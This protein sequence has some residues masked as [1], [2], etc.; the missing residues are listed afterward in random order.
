MRRPRRATPGRWTGAWPRWL[1]AACHCG[2]RLTRPRRRP[3]SRPGARA[4][5]VW[6]AGTAKRSPCSRSASPISPPPSPDSPCRRHPRKPV[7]AV[8]RFAS[9]SAAARWRRCHGAGRC[10]L[11]PSRP[12]WTCWPSRSHASPR[13]TAGCRNATRKP[14]WRCCRLPL[15]ARATSISSTSSR[16][17]SRTPGRARPSA[18][19]ARRRRPPPRSARSLRSRHC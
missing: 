17:R 7:R 19:G 2:W 6:S 18:R 16:Q 12:M 5:R 14:S 11:T 1:L 15:R 8:V 13:R 9:R 3:T 10:T 4:S